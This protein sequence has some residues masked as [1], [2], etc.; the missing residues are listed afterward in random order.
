MFYTGAPWAI[1]SLVPVLASCGSVTAKDNEIQVHLV[2]MTICLSEP[3]GESR[4]QTS[5]DV[6]WWSSLQVRTQKSLVTHKLNSTPMKWGYFLPF[7]KE[8]SGNAKPFPVRKCASLLQSKIIGWPRPQQWQTGK[9]GRALWAERLCLG[10]HWSHTQKCAQM[11]VYCEE[12]PS[13]QVWYHPTIN[14]GIVP[15]LLPL[16]AHGRC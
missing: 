1:A 13:R 8:E 10:S 14:K 3:W 7:S 5:S 11:W 4:V 16:E 15:I 12:F 6:Q 2:I 9:A